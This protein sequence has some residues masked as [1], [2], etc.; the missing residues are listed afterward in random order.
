ML[1]TSTLARQI[2]A[3]QNLESTVLSQLNAIGANEKVRW[4]GRSDLEMLG[5][6]KL[7]CDGSRGRGAA[8]NQ[9]AKTKNKHMLCC[10][11]IRLRYRKFKI[12][13]GETRY[14]CTLS[15]CSRY[16]MQT[17]VCMRGY[18]GRLTNIRSLRQHLHGRPQNPAQHKP[19]QT[20]DACTSSR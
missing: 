17:N 5:M 10:G 11:E 9:M 20:R 13:R 16:Y 12:Q 7:T 15:C 2:M 19:K 8:Q 6:S 4:Q 3:R 1:Q 18:L 14:R